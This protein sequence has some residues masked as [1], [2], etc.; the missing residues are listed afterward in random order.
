[1]DLFGTKFYERQVWEIQEV[2]THPHLHLDECGAL[3]AGER[4]GEDLFP[5]LLQ[6]KLTFFERHVHLDDQSEMSWLQKG[7]LFLGV[8]GGMFD[9]HP[10]EQYPEH[11]TMTLMMSYL[12]VDQD[13]ALQKVERHVFVADRRPGMHPF[14]LANLVKDAHRS[15]SVPDI[16]QHVQAFLESQYLAERGFQEA[17]TIVRTRGERKLV[18]SRR[19]PKVSLTL[20][21]SDGEDNEDLAKAARHTDGAHAALV[22]L[23]KTT[24][25]VYIVGTDQFIK[26]SLAPLAAQLR[27]AEQE[28]R[29]HV[30]STDLEDLAVPDEHPLVREWFLF[31]GQ[32]MNGSL[33]A[34][35]VP[36]TKIML[37]RIVSEATAFLE[38]AELQPRMAR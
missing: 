27:L 16:Y 8:R 19:H 22:I 2:V 30:E 33:T 35:D 11:C 5:R 4:F 14:H 36:P 12:G 17:L 28:A 25:H 15:L 9:D 23:K 3:W 26:N 21:V 37:S 13:P 1:M 7:V 38:H 31:H 24:G 6:A 18:Q 29:G 20:Y 34:P 32:L 10:H